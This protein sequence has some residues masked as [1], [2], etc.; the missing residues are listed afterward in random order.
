MGASGNLGPT[1]SKEELI[2][3]HTI[4]YQP[5]LSSD[6][7]YIIRIFYTGGIDISRWLILVVQDTGISHEVRRPSAAALRVL[8]R[9]RGRGGACN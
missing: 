1:S 2:P 3:Y 6:D 4:P 5:A 8:H 9:E 7:R